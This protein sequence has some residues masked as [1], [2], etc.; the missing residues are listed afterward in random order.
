MMQLALIGADIVAI[1]VLVFGIYLPRYHRG[2]LVVALFGLNVGTL[3]VATALS[4]TS[5]S[6][7]LG[8]G[9]FGVL[10]IVRLRSDELGQ[11]DVAFYFSALA[12]GLLAGL[13]PD[14]TWV[15]PGLMAL[16]VFTMFAVTRSG[17]VGGHQYVSMRLDRAFPDEEAARSYVGEM[18]GQ[19]PARLAIT[20]VDYV[21]DSTQVEVRYRR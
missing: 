21:N 2:D 20:H 19:P 7:G 17:V 9:L 8:L 11:E 10:S 5:V 16:I 12:L 3:A 18:L 6:A 14:P 13:S 4:S 15:G 1:I